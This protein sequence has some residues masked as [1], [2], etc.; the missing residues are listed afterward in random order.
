MEG[1]VPWTW[2]PHEEVGHT[3]EAKKE[4]QFIFS[5]QTAFDTA[6]RPRRGIDGSAY[7][8]YPASPA[9]GELDGAFLRDPC[10]K[11]PRDQPWV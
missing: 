2:C 8:L 9:S 1:F 4:I 10:R 3:D 11:L 7:F 6:E 5:A